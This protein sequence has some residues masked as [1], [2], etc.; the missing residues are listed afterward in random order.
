MPAQSTSANWIRSVL[1]RYMYSQQMLSKILE[2]ICISRKGWLHA[3][4]VNFEVLHCCLHCIIGSCS[5]DIFY[6]TVVYLFSALNATTWHSD[7]ISC[8]YCSR[9]QS[10]LSEHSFHAG[11]PCTQVS[12]Y[13]FDKNDCRRT[14]NLNSM[15]F[16]VLRTCMFIRCTQAMHYMYRACL[17]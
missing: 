7:Q 1:H 15:T 8:C 14:C 5:F 2:V 11:S 10:C 13:F 16:M 12:G 9:C 17:Y 4:I 3:G 6:D